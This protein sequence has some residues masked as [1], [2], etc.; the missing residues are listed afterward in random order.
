[1]AAALLAL[2][3]LVPLHDLPWTGFMG[4]L[5]AAV[6]L[7]LL[8][9]RS[10]AR[11]WPWLALVVLALALVPLAQ[12]ATG[13]VL[14][15]GDAVMASLYLVGLAFTI[16]I[17][18]QPGFV[19][20]GEAGRF[21]KAVL[22]AALVSSAIVLLYAAGWL[23]AGPWL[24]PQ[25][26]VGRAVANLGQPNLLSTLLVLGLIALLAGYPAKR[27]ERLA[28]SAATGLLLVA[29]AMTGS[30][31][32]LLQAVL[33]LGIALPAPH[34]LGLKLKRGGLLVLLVT[35]LAAVLATHVLQQ[36]TLARSWTHGESIVARWDYA[37]LFLAALQ[38][39]PWAGYGFNQVSVAQSR[40]MLLTP[41]PPA[42]T[43]HSH[44]LVID[45]LLW[46]GLPLGLPLLAGLASV[47][48][49]GLH[50]MRGDPMLGPVMLALLMLTVHAM[51]EY[52]LDYFIFLLPF[53]LLLGRL[54]AQDR[55]VELPAVVG[56]SVIAATVLVLMVSVVD[57]RRIAPQLA[58]ARL[59]LVQPM[60][61]PDEPAGMLL[62]DQL[63]AQYEMARYVGRPEAGSVSL[64]AME[65][66]TER[67]AYLA[68]IARLAID[69][70]AQGDVAM[71]VRL[72]QR[73][74]TMRPPRLGGPSPSQR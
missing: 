26:R 71:A 44:N 31:T 65:A 74:A 12:H 36:G 28:A 48:W 46:C 29:L 42:W 57:Y 56:R 73:L 1:M 72:R 62:L 54:C 53:G 13:L 22:A 6:A 43:E 70:Q 18:A 27:R 11:H 39:S 68:V 55:S 63:Q 7:L 34:R 21:A 66:A 59:A 51:L 69:A 64:L 4:D 45:L 9:M 10:P 38:D 2:G 35:L 52:P 24:G 19:A 58:Q 47:F 20:D 37:K 61:L 50:K 41:S 16:Q 3:F 14:Y 32:G 25:T 40:Q 23:P 67:F 5:C 33:L 15:R 30:R 17:G 49:R 60:L 8:A